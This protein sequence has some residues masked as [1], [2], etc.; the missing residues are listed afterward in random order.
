[1]L[2]DFFNLAL[3]HSLDMFASSMDNA[4][5]ISLITSIPGLIL[6]FLT[7][8]NYFVEYNVNMHHLNLTLILLALKFVDRFTRKSSL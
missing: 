4:L 6:N 7:R 3:S 1:M 8:G 2:F 5:L